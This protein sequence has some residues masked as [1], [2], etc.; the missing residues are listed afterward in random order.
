MAVRLN[1]KIV[2]PEI[3]AVQS[4]QDRLYSRVHQ[5]PMFLGRYGRLW[6]SSVLLFTDLF[7]L[8][9]A[10]GLALILRSAIMKDG[11]SILP[12][13][14]DYP[15]L[16]L[17]IMIYAWRGLY[18]AV[19][20]SPVE[21]LR[22]LASATSTVFLILIAITFS[23]KIT[24]NFSRLIFAF[25][26]FFSLILVQFD[27]WLVRVIARKLKLWGE[28]VA[29]V[30]NGPESE[31]IVDYLNRSI[32]MGFR[33][34]ILINGR[35]PC[36]E[37]LSSTLKA[38]GIRSAILI[39]P[40]ISDKMRHI[41]INEQRLGFNRL[42]LISSLGWVG[43]LGVVPHDLEGV[44]ALELRQNLLH[45]TDRLLKRSL[46]IVVSLFSLILAFPALALIAILIKLDSPGPLLYHHLR[47]GKDGQWI[48]VLKFRT[49]VCN[50]DQVLEEYLKKHPELRA[51]W[52]EFQKLKNDPRVTNVGRFLRRFSLDEVPQFWNILKGQ[53]SLV[54]PRPIVG[55]EIKNYKDVF[56]LYKRVHPGLT[57]LWQVSG[58][59]DTKYDERVRYDEYYIRNW[60]IWLDF[61]ILIRTVWVVL[62]RKGAY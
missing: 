18:N 33:P 13:I 8:S 3:S 35:G 56:T 48:K 26:W 49:M 28:P 15:V 41:I 16:A 51:E 53:M 59:N 62:E 43:S 36:D 10:I 47:V 52:E 11:D 61:Y 38:S 30:G 32:R 1:S 20:L 31:Y 57:G 34:A 12:Y 21:E 58:R 37:N 4:R 54:G 27:R 9:V 40:E 22:Q 45:S 24:L 39:L 25:S 60:S 19:G 23:F 55:D 2:T 50:A 14:K 29:I 42:Y 6:M 5:K 7:S 46:D 44:L 17:F